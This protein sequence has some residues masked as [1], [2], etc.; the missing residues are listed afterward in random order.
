MRAHLGRVEK[1]MGGLLVLTGFAFLSGW[2]TQASYWLLES[3]PV[4]S[5]FG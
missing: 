4:L 1:I 3:F 5:R 2:I